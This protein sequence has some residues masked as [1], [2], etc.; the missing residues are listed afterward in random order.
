VCQV[1]KKFGR[2]NVTEIF[3]IYFPCMR[4]LSWSRASSVSIVT[5]Y[6]LDYPAIEVR[7]PTRAKD[8]SSSL[9]VQTSSEVH[10]ASCP[11]GTGGP[12]PGGVA[13]RDLTLT[14]HPHLVSRSWMSRSSTSS[15]PCSSMA[16]CGT[17]NSSL[18]SPKH[19]EFCGCIVSL[20]H[21]TRK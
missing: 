20:P 10:P 17:A 12:F 15:R 16:C 13:R 21:T 1:R 19:Y 2:R 6:G 4:T 11:M 7:S 8:F 3:S 18:G 14:I 9:C 5:G